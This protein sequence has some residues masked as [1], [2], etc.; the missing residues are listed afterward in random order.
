V[1]LHIQ[2][3][4]EITGGLNFFRD[5]AMAIISSIETTAATRQLN[6]WGRTPEE[7]ETYRREQEERN[8][9]I[10]ER[11]SAEIVVTLRADR[12]KLIRA[13]RRMRETAVAWKG[14]TLGLEYEMS[15]VKI[16]DLT[17]TRF[18]Q[19][20]QDIRSA[21]QLHSFLE[22]I[23]TTPAEEI[24]YE[25]YFDAIL[26]SYRTKSESNR[27]LLIDSLEAEEDLK[28][29]ISE[30]D[31]AITENMEQIEHQQGHAEDVPLEDHV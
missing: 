8:R 9:E 10:D 19:E 13:W 24:R 1:E 16:G 18:A 5:S 29:V 20:R 17:F 4:F 27:I 30:M 12:Q 23:R 28:L 6:R 31:N 21:E 11:L 26:N 2:I 14:K 22:R 3:Y 7:E 15:T 25:A